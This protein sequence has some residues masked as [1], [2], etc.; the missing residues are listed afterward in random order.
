MI[1]FSAYRPVGM[2]SAPAH[3][4]A[5]NVN[6]A[7]NNLQK[8]LGFP[9]LVDDVLT[10]HQVYAPMLKQAMN[11]QED[12]V[13]DHAFVQIDANNLKAVET[14][15]NNYPDGKNGFKNHNG[16]WFNVVNVPSLIYTTNGDM[17]WLEVACP[18]P[19]SD[20]PNG[21]KHMAY[22]I[23]DQAAYNDFRDRFF[24]QDF[25]ALTQKVNIGVGV[26][27][28]GLKVNKDASGSLSSM[29]I[30]ITERGM[31]PF[32]IELRTKV[33]KD[34]LWPDLQPSLPS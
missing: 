8:A 26:K 4:G 29:H 19:D 23:K 17:N 21:L 2:V 15:V 9:A 20:E 7:R 11:L 28:K 25:E 13:L 10:K 33:L 27:A 30:L 3:F 24:N 32:E 5:G 6:T 1:T 14:A 31:E 22:F 16:R 18:K 34:T 12:P